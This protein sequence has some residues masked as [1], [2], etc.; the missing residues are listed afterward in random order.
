[1]RSR[2]LRV[3]PTRMWVLTLLTTEPRPMSHSDLVGRLPGEIDRTTVFRALVT[4]SD[5]RLLHRVDVGDRVWRYT[6][7]IVTDV[8]TPPTTFVCTECGSVQVLREAH[9]EVLGPP[10]AL[11]KHAVR[12]FVHGL[13]D[14]CGP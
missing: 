5:A 2:G 11:R 1:M 9:L 6:R 7:S 3:T 12:I 8:D 4:L 14:D 13:C 10:R